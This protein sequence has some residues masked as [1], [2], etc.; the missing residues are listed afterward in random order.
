MWLIRYFQERK[1]KKSETRI[2]YI[3][4]NYANRGIM[5]SVL[6]LFSAASLLYS[7]YRAY[8]LEGNADL[9]AAASCFCSVL[10]S[11][12]GIGY[13]LGAFLQEDRNYF[14]AKLGLFFH[15]LLLAGIV[16]VLILSWR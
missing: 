1:N 14:Y 12:T 6:V 10:I 4:K 2:S 8:R 11:F 16:A 9:T 15:G 13:A 3:K 7:V 5:S